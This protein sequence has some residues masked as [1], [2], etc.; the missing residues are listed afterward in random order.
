VNNG[1]S[2]TFTHVGVTNVSGVVY[3]D[4]FNGPGFTGKYAWR[5]ATYYIDG[6]N[7]VTWQPY[8]TAYWLKWG[9]PAAGYSVLSSGSLTG[10][11]GDAGVTYTYTDSTGTNHLG[12]IP[13]ASLPAGPSAFFRLQNPNP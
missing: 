10:P 1:K 2:A 11:W 13:T 8:G 6:A 12:A 5:V 4:S 7:R 3:D 9:E